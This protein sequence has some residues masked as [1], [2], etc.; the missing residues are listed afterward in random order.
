M[1]HGLGVKACLARHESSHEPQRAPCKSRQGVALAIQDDRGA[2]VFTIPVRLTTC[3]RG[4]SQSRG[5]N[6]IRHTIRS[7]ELDS[8][9][10]L[11]IV[12]HEHA[13][14]IFAYGRKFKSYIM[15]AMAHSP[16]SKT[17]SRRSPPCP[18]LQGVE[19][20]SVNSSEYASH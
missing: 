12:G 1:S 18:P 16:S 19:L 2:T 14:D 13:G 4:Q 8:L 17:N 15:Q 3:A 20:P 10:F 9:Y 5:V 7:D 6:K 11:I